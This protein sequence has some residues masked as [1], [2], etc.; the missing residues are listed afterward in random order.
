MFCT[1]LTDL[2]LYLDRIKKI[3]VK[4]KNISIILNKNLINHNRYLRRPIGG[5]TGRRFCL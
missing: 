3:R 2:L 1:V 4:K 5:L